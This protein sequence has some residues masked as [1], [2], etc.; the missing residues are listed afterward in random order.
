MPKGVVV[1]GLVGFHVTKQLGL[2]TLVTLCTWTV[3]PA[4]FKPI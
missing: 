2:P 3:A 1:Q 4:L